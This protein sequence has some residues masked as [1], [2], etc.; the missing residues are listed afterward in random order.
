M[1][2]DTLFQSR[3]PLM[4]TAL[5]AYALRQ[6][7][8]AKNVANATSTDYRPEKVKFEDF[9]QDANIS[10]KGIKDNELHIDLGK[11][12]INL[13]KPVKEEAEIPRAEVLFAGESHVNIDKEMSELAQNQIRFRLVSRTLRNYMMALQTAISGIVR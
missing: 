4:Q 12:I 7:T 3:I 11:P 13:V 1:I 2:K 6:Q 8:I 10:L 9:F 5:D